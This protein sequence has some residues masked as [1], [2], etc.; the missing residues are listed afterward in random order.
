MATHNP[1]RVGMSLP[2]LAMAMSPDST[3]PP[4]VMEE[5]TSTATVALTCLD[6]SE[7][8]SLMAIAGG[9]MTMSTAALAMVETVA[10]MAP[11]TRND[12]RNQ[13]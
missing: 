7:A 9:T 12:G 11:G 4:S 2:A 3:V 5:A 13:L 6:R 8:K 10:D 1:A